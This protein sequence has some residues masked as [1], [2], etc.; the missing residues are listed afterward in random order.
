MY[1]SKEPSIVCIC[2]NGWCAVYTSRSERNSGRRYLKCNKCCFFAWVDDVAQ[3]ANQI[4]ESEEFKS[5]RAEVVKLRAET[6]ELKN[7]ANKGKATACELAR[8]IGKIVIE[9][10]YDY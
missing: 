4:P 8:A 2:G 7:K 5:L 10:D 1:Y 9:E 3:M 6:E